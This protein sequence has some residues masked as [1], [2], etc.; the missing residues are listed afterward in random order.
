[1]GGV[2]VSDAK[3]SFLPHAHA[4]IRRGG[5]WLPLTVRSVEHLDGGKL[6]VVAKGG[7]RWDC[8]IN[9]VRSEDERLADVILQARKRG[10]GDK[11]TSILRGIADLT[12]SIVRGEKPE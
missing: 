7:G 4:Q 5:A 1:M 11:V 10:I 9:S 8:P 2:L 6:R 3:V 12:D